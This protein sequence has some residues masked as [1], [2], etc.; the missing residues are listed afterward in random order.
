MFINFDEL[1]D[2]AHE[3]SHPFSS[4]IV[5]TYEGVLQLILCFPH[6]TFSISRSQCSIKAPARLYT[7]TYILAGALIEH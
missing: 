5:T 7:L 2:I 3:M 1:C 4:K 6:T